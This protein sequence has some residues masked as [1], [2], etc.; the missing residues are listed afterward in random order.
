MPPP[1]FGICL[2]P[3][4]GWPIR[5]GIC[6][7]PWSGVCFLLWFGCSKRLG[8]CLLFPPRFGLPPAQDLLPRPWFGCSKRIGVCPLFPPWFGMCLLPRIGICPLPWLGPLLLA[9]IHYPER[10]YVLRFRLGWRYYVGQ[11]NA[12]SVIG[13][14]LR[15]VSS[16]IASA[17][18]AS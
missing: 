15:W 12:T 7:P 2:P 5:L 3:W 14:A 18:C 9:Q 10:A 6:L 13:I 16:A 8:V 4:I 17:I 11:V 1:W